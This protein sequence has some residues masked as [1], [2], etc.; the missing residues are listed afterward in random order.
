M[1]EHPQKEKLFTKDYIFIC[2]ANF[3]LSFAFYL[4][5]PTLPL[6]LVE[7]LHISKSI[8]GIILSSFTIAVLAI[9]PFSG[10]IADSFPRK[11]IYLV[12][13][14]MFI[15]LFFG[16]LIAG[17]FT[18][19]LFLRIIHGASFGLLS[20][21]S[22]TLAIDIMPSSRRGEGLGYYGIMG[23][24]AMA[25]GPMTGLFLYH[26][27]TFEWIFITAIIAGIL[28]SIFAA[29]I[30][31]PQRQVIESQIISL[32][33]FFLLK[34]IR[35]AICFML[36]AIPYS[37]TTSYITLYLKENGFTINTGLFFTFMATGM[38]LSRLISGKK[39]DK[40]LITQTITMGMIFAALGFFGE[41]FLVKI[42][43][44]DILTGKIFFY[45]IA[46]AIGYGF[47][48]LF[49]AFNTLFLNLAPHT[50]RATANATYLTGWDVG[51]GL[52]VYFGGVMSD[53]IGF[54]GVYSVGFV[55]FTLALLLFVWIV[56]PH[57]NKNCLR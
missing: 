6:Y 35:A 53:T 51:I 1:S 48:T 57:F 8:A 3:L 15:A 37:M 54:R 27:S 50:R 22:N 14:F 29:A 42:L 49:P 52:G 55:V 32:E 47:G 19:L 24:L 40:G 11:P 34:G 45:L 16:Y 4:L 5:I 21:S 30:K 12:A 26:S 56:T 10:F 41:V 2:M 23:S 33:R 36:M 38:I 43:S 44:A 18:A 17:T 7:T 25:I 31:T 28:G 20:T 39:V 13:Y 9:R 46:G